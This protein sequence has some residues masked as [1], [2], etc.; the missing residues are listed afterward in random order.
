MRKGSLIVALVVLPLLAP[1]AAPAETPVIVRVPAALVVEHPKN[2]ASGTIHVKNTSKT[3]VPVYLSAEDFVAKSTGAPLGTTV[4]FSLPGGTAR[5]PVYDATVAPGASVAVNVEVTNLWEAGEATARLFNH[6]QVVDTLRAVKYRVPLAV[7]LLGAGENPPV[8]AFRRGAKRD[9]LVKN[10]DAMT[11]HVDW[12]LVV[13]DAV[14]RGSRVML[15]PN[16]TATIPVVPERAWF[17][18]PLEG[19]FKD[20][21]K[22]GTLTLRFSPGAVVSAG[23]SEQ[24][25][26][27]RAQLTFWPLWLRQPII[28]A[29]VFAALLAGGLCSLLLNQWFPNRIRR[30]D[31]EERL[32]EIATRTRNLSPRVDSGLRILVRVERYRLLRL[33]DSRYT[34]SPEMADVLT[35]AGQ[36]VA[37]LEQKVAILERID[38]VAS[39]VRRLRLAIP[40][41]TAD[42]VHAHLRKAGDRLKS[43]QP[44]DA[45]LQEAGA[46]VDAAAA[47]LAATGQT[48]P[49]LVTAL[50]ERFERLR[51]ELDVAA[52]ARADRKG[53]SLTRRLGGLFQYVDSAFPGAALRPDQYFE[54]DARLARLDLVLGYL[55]LFAHQPDEVR[56]RLEKTEGDLVTLIGASSWDKT[57]DARRLLQEMRD[58]IYTDEVEEEIRGRRLRIIAQPVDPRPHQAVELSA[59]FTRDAYNVC[60]A[61]EEYTCEWTFHHED[62]SGRVTTWRE[63]GWKVHHFFPAPKTYPVKVCFRRQDGSVVADR[64]ETVTV[65]GDVTVGSDTTS[66][67]GNRTKIEAMRF[68]I[69]LVAT[70][71]GLIGGARDQLMKLDVVAGLIAVFLVGFGADAVK[72]ILVDRSAA[73]AAKK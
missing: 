39:D 67:F 4:A 34:F 5:A 25:I 60:G 42:G 15:P 56:A 33:L 20:E 52:P 49:E 27:L 30:V 55:T 40:P 8:L 62:S 63:D 37:R 28:M 19:F 72:N 11:Y 36:A 70:I 3:P 64:T 71:V 69:V 47:S 26:A 51:K 53:Q 10:D 61:R 32:G 2:V 59:V 9:V 66:M 38:T 14:A 22:D 24:S 6:D 73:P 48:D 23:V 18:A 16:G 57:L 17:S 41:M 45:E 35:A 29:V 21:V 43:P 58:D 12:A 1:A 46:L 7:R 44:S 65:T 50:T 31:L 13:G 54:H 68:G